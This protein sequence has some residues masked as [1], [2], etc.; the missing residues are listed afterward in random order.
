MAKQ[1]KETKFT[2][3]QLELIAKKLGIKPENLLSIEV[4]TDGNGPQKKC[5][6]GG[7]IFRPDCC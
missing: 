2:K 3:K 7:G 4:M 6:C 1:P 5:H